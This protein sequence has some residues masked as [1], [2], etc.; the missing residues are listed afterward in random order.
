MV[1][2]RDYRNKT[3]HIWKFDLWHMDF[4]I[5]EHYLFISI[6]N[7]GITNYPHG[8]SEFTSY[9]SHKNQLLGNL[10]IKCEKQNHKA[11]SW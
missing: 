7:V 2:K 3:T 6:N 10:R 11:F 1:Q 8:K 9:I 4:P 5:M